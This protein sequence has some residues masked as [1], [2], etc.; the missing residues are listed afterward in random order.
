MKV[1][2]IMTKSPAYCTPEDGL[3]A[4]ARMMCDSD[5]GELPVVESKQSMMPVGV[6]TDRDITCRS[7]ARGKNP[8]ELQVSDIMSSPAVTVTPETEVDV[9]CMLLE[10]RR[11]RRV[12]VVDDRGRLCGIV[13]Q[14]DIARKCG[15]D[16]AGE[17]VSKVSLAAV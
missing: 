8:L 6:I 16:K 1:K 15:V 14:A 2:E 13:S 3:Q 5:C 10:E 7:V 4:A 9:C 17:V 11:I 12:P